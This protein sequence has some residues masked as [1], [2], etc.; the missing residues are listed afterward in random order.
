[1]KVLEHLS[2]AELVP[3]SGEHVEPNE[4][5][6]SLTQGN[7]D[8]VDL[9]SLGYKNEKICGGVGKLLELPFFLTYDKA[10]S[11]RNSQKFRFNTIQTNR[12]T[13]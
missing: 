6:V 7:K 13:Q 4:L 10:M 8:A 12:Q 3:M 5:H 2:H 11:L 1:M 9:A